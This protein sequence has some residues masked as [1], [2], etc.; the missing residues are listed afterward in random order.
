MV[1]HHFAAEYCIRTFV[2]DPQTYFEIP[3]RTDTRSVHQSSKKSVLGSIRQP[4]T[5]S[6][7]DV[8]GLDGSDDPET[9]HACSG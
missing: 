1:S 3:E 4:E 6:T 5:F 8:I 7:G 2:I 9:D